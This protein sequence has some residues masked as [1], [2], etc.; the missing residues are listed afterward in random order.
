[1]ASC[2][3]FRADWPD[4]SK[5][6]TK[7]SGAAEMSNAPSCRESSQLSRLRLA[8]SRHAGWLETNTTLA[9]PSKPA[10]PSRAKLWRVSFKRPQLNRLFSK[11]LFS[12]SVTMF[13]SC[14]GLATR[15]ALS[16]Q[17]GGCVGGLKCWSLGSRL[18]D[19][20]L[21][22]VIPS[23]EGCAILGDKN[24]KNIISNSS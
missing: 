14:Q 2:S 23:F 22:R 11:L 15:T 6:G 10:K 21:Y 17:V 3:S 4:A 1:M 7:V 13:L 19:R 20:L 18:P 5:N 24:A 9:R 16:V 12:L 8:L